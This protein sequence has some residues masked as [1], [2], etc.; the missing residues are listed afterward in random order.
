MGVNYA[1]PV[2]TARMTATRDHF[3]G[4]TLELGT[5]GMRSVLVSF[6]LSGDGGTV[7][8]DVWSFGFQLNSVLGSAAG[9]AVEARVKTQDGSSNLVGLTVGTEQADIILDNTSIKPG[10]NVTLSSGAI[11]H[12]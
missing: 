1:T 2:K 6:P 7:K 9:D 4:G 3:A 10:Q 5:S 12:A 8:D 11:K